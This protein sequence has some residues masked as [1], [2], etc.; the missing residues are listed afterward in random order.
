MD[1]GSR[2]AFFMLFVLAAGCHERRE[3]P[4]AAWRSDAEVLFWDVFSHQ[5][6]ARIPEVIAAL[7]KATRAEPG[8]ARLVLL[9]GVTHMW[10][11]A[12]VGVA[13]TR[14][15]AKEAQAGIAALERYHAM[16][17]GDPRVPTWEGPLLAGAGFGMQPRI[18]QLPDGPEKAALAKR[19]QDLI[20]QA[21]A[22]LDG[23]VVAE[24]RFNLFG[25]FITT[26]LLPRNTERFHQAVSDVSAFQEARLGAKLD[27]ER[28]DITPFL[29]ADSPCDPAHPPPWP[30]EA[31]S[32]QTTFRR[33]PKCWNSWKTPFEYEGAWLYMGDIL[34][35]GGRAAAARV[36]YQNGQKL[37]SYS[38]WPY[39]V[40][41]EDR[42][43]HLDELAAKFADQDPSNDPELV[44]RAPAN[45]LICHA[46][47]HQS[48]ILQVQ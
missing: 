26:G 3:K 45:C 27:P 8:N 11:V 17:P 13:H 10:A 25:R 35:K 24:P 5:Q 46:S 33:D 36:T 30:F 47:P 48:P 18:A 21:L 16:A 42:L 34:L 19:S 7:E 14:D 37:T 4:P 38:Q 12:E 22:L 20:A 23:G 28:P 31:L 9:L 32:E 41:L 2:A 15:S 29:K 6:H 39:A 1:A 44:I 40:I 43:S